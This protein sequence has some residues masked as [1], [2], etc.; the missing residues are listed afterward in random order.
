MT[1]GGC[2]LSAAG[3]TAAASAWGTSG[4]TRRHL[5]AG[6]ENEGSDY[7]VLWTEL[8]F[9]VLAGAVLPALAWGLLAY[10]L[11]RRGRSRRHR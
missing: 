2:V 6:F 7:T 1:C 11:S 9:V 4:R 3:A 10:L 5:G 8:P